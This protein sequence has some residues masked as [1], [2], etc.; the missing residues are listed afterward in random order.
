[1]IE[2]ISIL[3]VWRLTRLIGD[4]SGPYNL[5]AKAR[6]RFYHRSGRPNGIIGELLDCFWCL[7]VWVAFPVALLIA[8]PTVGYAL[9]YW[10]GLSAGAILV[11]SYVREV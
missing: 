8:P 5:F 11:N 10:F 2:L 6:G 9:L 3:A 1:M 7:S 4:E